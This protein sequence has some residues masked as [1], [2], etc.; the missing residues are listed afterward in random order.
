M[1]K[2]GLLF[3][4][5]VFWQNVSAQSKA[6]DIPVAKLPPEVKAVLEEYVKILT[7]SQDLDDCAKR[8]TSIAGGGLIN[9]DPDNVTL[10]QGVQP[11]SLKKDF[12]NIKFYAQ[13]I[14][15]TR[16][17]VSRT[18]GSGYGASAVAGTVYK[19]WIDKK[20]PQQGMP[21]PVSIV[22]P[23]NHASIKTPKVI[24]IGSF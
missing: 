16:V 24:G 17:N 8:F 23:E 13:P 3:L 15:I 10:R 14:K 12:N 1:K 20:N 21:A 22:V 11:F 4:C 6:N 2:I 5:L 9:E 7:T 18:N 19:I